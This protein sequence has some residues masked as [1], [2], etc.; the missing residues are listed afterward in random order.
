MPRPTAVVL[1]AAASDP[2]IVP[3]LVIVPP[4]T[5]SPSLAE[6]TAFFERMAPVLV[7]LT[8]PSSID[9]V[10]VAGNTVAGDH[11]VD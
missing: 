7:M 9:A 6:P 3:E 2:W 10:T 1:P 4:P 5:E 11:A 8:R